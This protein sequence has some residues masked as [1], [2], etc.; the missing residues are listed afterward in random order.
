MSNQNKTI[1]VTGGAGFIG[2]N[3]IPYYLEQFPEHHILPCI[4]MLLSS[5]S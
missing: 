2:S 1:L 5:R 3:F 4:Q